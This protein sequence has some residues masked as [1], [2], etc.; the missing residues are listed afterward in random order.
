[1]EFALFDLLVCQ[2]IVRLFLVLKIIS[3]DFMDPNPFFIYI[4]RSL[5]FLQVCSFFS[6]L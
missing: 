1:V 2:P 6:F 3:I 4:I 5:V